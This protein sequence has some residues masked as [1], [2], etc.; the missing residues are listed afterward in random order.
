VN[1]QTTIL[2]VAEQA[3]APGTFNGHIHRATL[4]SAES[5][6][7][8][9][10]WWLAVRRKFFRVEDGKR[11]AVSE[12]ESLEAAPGRVR[13]PLQAIY[14]DPRAGRDWVTSEVEVAVPAGPAPESL[15]E[16]AARTR[17]DA[18]R[19]RP[20]FEAAL[21]GGV[22]DDEL[23]LLRDPQT[24]SDKLFAKELSEQLEWLRKHDE[25]SADA[26]SMPGAIP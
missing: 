18:L 23:R 5:N 8:Q 12:A 14:R 19:I 2:D 17:R 1:L 16:I 9:Y 11:V 10:L 4:L 15:L 25:L 13:V 26:G 21:H 6:G 22:K 3:V 24:V 20:A 7:V